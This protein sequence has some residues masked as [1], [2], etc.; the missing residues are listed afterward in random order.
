MSS[1]NWVNQKYLNISFTCYMLHLNLTSL[2][3]ESFSKAFENLVLEEEKSLDNKLLDESLESSDSVKG[4]SE[5]VGPVL[6]I[7]GS[8]EVGSSKTGE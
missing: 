1:F 8:R 3:T 6:I 7:T 2:Q 5:L 4:L